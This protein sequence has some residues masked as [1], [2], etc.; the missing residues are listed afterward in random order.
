MGRN[1]GE[2]ARVGG[3]DRGNHG[4]RLL[5]ASQQTADCGYPLGLDAASDRKSYVVEGSLE[6]AQDRD[7]GAV[8]QGGA[9][10]RGEG[11]PENEYRPEEPGEPF[12]NPPRAAK[13][14]HFE[15]QPGRLGGS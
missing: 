9:G 2:G 1:G 8:A 12:A 3:C 11:R 13:S 4:D 15:P 6:T 5:I 7:P 10:R 14:D